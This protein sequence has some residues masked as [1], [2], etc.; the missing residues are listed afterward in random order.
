MALER[1]QKII[2]AIIRGEQH[3]T[4]D[5]ALKC[6]GLENLET[7]RTNLCITFPFKA[8]K[9]PNFSNWF[10]ENTTE[11]NKRSE[12][13]PLKKIY[14]RTRKNRITPLPYLTDLMNTHFSK[15]RR[16]VENNHNNFINML[17]QQTTP[18]TD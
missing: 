11:V 15:Q 12:K 6:F 10:K 2:L 18:L 14:T 8:S 16:L 9:S 7:R 5:K 13:L 4:Y 17:N 1:V 3:T